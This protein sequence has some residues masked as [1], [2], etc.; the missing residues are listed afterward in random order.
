MTAVL[1]EG[2]SMRSLPVLTVLLALG[3]TAC[4]SSASPTTPTTPVAVATTSLFYAGTV[5][6]VGAEV[7]ANVEATVEVPVSQLAGSTSDSS[8]KISI[9]V[10][11]A[12][13]TLK[14]GT[15]VPL[16]GSF[17]TVTQKV[18]LTSADLKYRIVIDI[19]KS[20]ASP[21]G[22]FTTS[23]GK[24]GGINIVQTIAPAPPTLFCG[25]FSG[26]SKGW[27][28]VTRVGDVLTGFADDG[29]GQ[30]KLT[31]T[32]APIGGGVTIKWTFTGEPGGGT[33]TGTLLGGTM[34]SG[35]WSNTLGEKGLWSSQSGFLGC[36]S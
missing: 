23:D 31:G 17:D 24:V 36:G 19:S 29:F 2:S 20:K 35:L 14:N 33:A 21:D 6:T 25:T 11:T 12:K 15:V 30:I 18:T 1:F 10:T 4:G 9:P 5:A 34:M 13:L 7:L 16:S 28:N 32:V 26:D 8:T 22:T 27:M 3:T